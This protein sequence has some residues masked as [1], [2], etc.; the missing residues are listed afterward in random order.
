MKA[1]GPA[2]SIRQSNHLE[3]KTMPIANPYPLPK[4]V[5]FRQGTR[6]EHG[7]PIGQGGK[8]RLQSKSEAEQRLRKLCTQAASPRSEQIEL[9]VFVALGLLAVAAIASCF[10]ELLHLLATDAIGKT[11]QALLTR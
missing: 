2:T 4:R 10:S 7:C 8:I 1:A 6:D 11:V 3:P 5:P 9:A